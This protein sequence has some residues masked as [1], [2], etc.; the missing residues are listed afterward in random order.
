MLKRINDIL[1][2]ISLV[3]LVVLT[4]AH[5]IPLLLNFEAIFM[6][7]RKQNVFLGTDQWLE[8]NE[9][10][11]RV[12]TMIAFLLHFRLLQ[13]TWSSRNG[14]ES[15]KTLWVSDK[16]VLCISFPLYIAI[17]L[18]A[19]LAHSLPN[20]HTK[21]R[22]H[23]APKNITFWGA[24]KSYTGL[25]LDTFLIPQI[26]FNLFCDTQGTVLAPAFYIGSTMVRLLPHVYDLYRTH[27]SSWF[28]N[29]IYANPGMDYYSATWDVVI[30]CGGMLCLLVIYI[31]QRFRGRSVLPKRF[32]DE[33]SYQKVPVI[34]QEQQVF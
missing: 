24:L 7:N 12:I 1:P 28:Y 20:S 3:M 26:I 34:T 19:W 25:V 33:V 31:Q 23:L 15:Q 6:L 29:K 9:V 10:L 8:V 27:S 16:K 21:T 18:A 22:F 30:C 11:V 4:L 5:M 2:F 17:G 32:R 13:L 14:H